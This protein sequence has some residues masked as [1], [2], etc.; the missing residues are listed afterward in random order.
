MQNLRFQ[1]FDRRVQIAR[2]FRRDSRAERKVQSG[3]SGS[4]RFGDSWYRGANV[5]PKLP[6]LPLEF[7]RS[8]SQSFRLVQDRRNSSYHCRTVSS[9]LAAQGDG[10][11]PCATANR[12][13]RRRPL[14]KEVFLFALPRLVS[15]LNS[16]PT[17]VV[18]NRNSHKYSNNSTSISSPFSSK[19]PIIFSIFIS[20]FTGRLLSLKSRSSRVFYPRISRY[21]SESFS[22]ELTVECLVT[23]SNAPFLISPFSPLHLE[24]L[25]FF[26]FSSFLNLSS[27]EKT[28]KIRVS[29]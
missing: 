6:E 4:T 26:S 17:L 3:S 12:P 13:V 19:F 7:G 15:S 24:I 27:F 14:V 25:G 11:A 18:V 16:I 29:K 8:R 20:D 22:R 2:N 9:R 28:G 5:R 23:C 1:R 21:E 10:F